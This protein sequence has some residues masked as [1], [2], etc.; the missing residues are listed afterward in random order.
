M[1]V[2]G[3]KFKEKVSWWLACLYEHIAGLQ[4]SWY[5]PVEKYVCVCVA[6]SCLLKH[7]HKD[8]AIACGG[9]VSDR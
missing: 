6:Q 9:P 3:V 2:V 4:L 5:Y 7:N 1:Q 8:V